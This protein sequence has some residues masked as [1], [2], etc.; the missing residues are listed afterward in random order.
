MKL[1]VLSSF[2]WL[3]SYNYNCSP[4]SAFA[5]RIRPLSR[6]VPW[7]HSPPACLDF[8]PSLKNSYK[9]N[10]SLRATPKESSRQDDVPKGTEPRR[11][12][13]RMVYSMWYAM[14]ALFPQ[15]RKVVRRQDSDLD[16]S[17]RLQDGLIGL[18]AYLSVGVLAYHCVFEKWSVVDA[19]YF[20]VACFSTVGCVVQYFAILNRCCLVS[21]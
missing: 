19:L 11:P 5:S 8:N 18:L 3:F 17:L 10:F 20:S 6:V 12:L 4:V 15:L 7:L 14:T 9:P 21:R 2:L 1:G 13:S 16:I